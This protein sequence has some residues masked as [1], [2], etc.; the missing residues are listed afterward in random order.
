MI[1]PCALQKHLTISF[2]FKLNASYLTGTDWYAN[3]YTDISASTLPQTA[4]Q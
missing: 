2:A 3:D 1:L 4:A